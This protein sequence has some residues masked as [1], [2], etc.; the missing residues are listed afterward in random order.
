M[1]RSIV[2]GFLDLHP[3]VRPS[4]KPTI[5]PDATET[6]VVHPTGVGEA[7]ASM[8]ARTAVMAV[9]SSVMRRAQTQV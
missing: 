4:D 5:K 2:A 9:P 3:T 8:A 1:T 7:T 6:V